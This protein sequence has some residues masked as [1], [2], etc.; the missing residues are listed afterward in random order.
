MCGRFTLTTSP[1]ELVSAFRLPEVPSIQPRY[2]VAPAQLVAVVGLKPAG[3]GASGLLLD[4]R[5]EPAVQDVVRLLADPTQLLVED[6]PDRP[7]RPPQLLADG[8]PPVGQLVLG[9]DRAPAP[10]RVGRPGR[11]S[12]GGEGGEGGEAHGRLRVGGGDGDG[13]S[14]RGRP[15]PTRKEPRRSPGLVSVRGEGPGPGPNG[16]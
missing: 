8:Q 10:G 3:P 1:D 4:R 7:V 15:Q 13:T 11:G 16:R 2:N 5:D 6:V 12:Q 14:A 9:D